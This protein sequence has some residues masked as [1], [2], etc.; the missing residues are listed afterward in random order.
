[1]DHHCPWIANCVGYH[2]YKFF[3]LLL[4]YAILCCLFVIGAL[5][6][7]LIRVFQP[8]LDPNYFLTKDLLVIVEVVVCL[9]LLITLCIFGSFHVWL[10][11]NAMT[12]I[13]Y[14]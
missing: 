9:F 7:R 13:E 3:L 1:M 14:K 8:I 6:P 10:V 4:F 2:N 11:A 12:T 5:I